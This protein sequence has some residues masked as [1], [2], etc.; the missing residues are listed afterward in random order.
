MHYLKML[1][2][3][4]DH[5]RYAHSVFQKKVLLLSTIFSLQFDYY[6]QHIDI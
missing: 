1:L 2:E 3:D 4:F 6:S 5:V